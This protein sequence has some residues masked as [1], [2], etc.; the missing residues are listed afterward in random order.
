[1]FRAND[2]DPVFLG[3]MSNSIP[4]SK[5]KAE[6]GQGDAVV[7]IY[8]G[9]IS[10]IKIPLPPTLTEQ[11]AIATALS[12]VDALIASLEQTITKKKAIKQGAIQQLLTPPNKGGKRLPGFSGE[13][14]EKTLGDVADFYKGK[15]LPKSEIKEGGQFP[16]VHYGEL[17]TKYNEIIY[18]VISRT[19]KSEDSF[20]SKSND[21]LM[22]TSDV[23]PNGLATASA[24]F[25]DDI[26]LG[27]D[28]LVIRP[29][30]QLY[31]SFLAFLVTINRPQ[32]MSLVSGST[33]YHLYGSDMSKFRFFMS[34]DIEEQKAIAQILSDMDAEIT[35]LENK[36]AKHQAIKQGMMQELLT[37]KT[38]LV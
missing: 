34:T 7:H 23:T 2:I 19:D 14:V 5:Q 4:V 26:I 25:E 13:W 20:T 12:D 3:F 27:G 38:R 37:G 21:V 6:N 18:T 32:I 28:V 30:S 29:H 31:G 33:V 1:V 35:Q 9:G 22:P 11:K 15:G 17:F 24:L 8:S 16:C 36:K 10:K